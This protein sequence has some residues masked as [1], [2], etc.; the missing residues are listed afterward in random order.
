MNKNFS[1]VIKGE[2]LSETQMMEA[3]NF[4]LDGRASND[5]LSPFLYELA[6]RGETVDEIVGAAKVLRE[7]AISIQSPPGT[8]DCCGTGGDLSGTYNISTAVAFVAASC[9]IP[10]A[11]HGNRA[12]TSKC[13]AADVLEILGINLNMP[14]ETQEEALEKFHFAFLLASRHHPAMKHVAV[15]RKKLGTPT[16][17]NLIGPLSNP[18]KAKLQLLGVYQKKWLRPMAESLQRLG[19]EKA[20][21][22]HGSDGL[23]EITVTGSTDVAI[24]ENGV[25]TQKTISP[26]DFDLPERKLSD[27]KGEDGPGNAKALR[28]V[29]EGQKCAYRDIVLANTAAVLNIHGT[30]DDLKTGVKVAAE[31]IDNGTALQTLK[32]YVVFS[33]AA[34]LI[35]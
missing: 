19:S 24:L 26:S 13:G 30:T 22:V 6:R 2:S 33:R 20:W 10:I 28:A 25:I 18:A 15:V 12:S 32:D 11:K 4:I 27:L 7:R 8:V 17:F 9:N 35:A 23:D 5:D 31:A 29:L 21:I 14:P 34:G 1:R 3:M 16:I